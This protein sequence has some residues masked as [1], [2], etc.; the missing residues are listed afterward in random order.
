MRI[1]VL[2]AL[3]LSLLGAAHAAP[4]SDAA[5]A[6]FAER[7]ALLAADAKCTLL[8]APVRAALNAT[9]GQARM[10]AIRAG[11]TDTRLD[12]VSTRA[13]DAGR[14]RDCKDPLVIDAAQRATAGYAG[15]S[16]QQGVDLP[17][18]SRSWRVRRLGDINGWVLAQELSP[19]VRF[20]L[21]YNTA[22][23]PVFVLTAPLAEMGTLSSVQV[24]LRDRTR[25]PRPLLNVPGLLPVSGLAGGVAPRSL[26]ATW[27][28]SKITVERV[29][30]TPPMVVVNFPSGL[31]AELASLD[32]RETAE[33][34]LTRVGAPPQRF[35]VEIG[36]LNVARAFLSAGAA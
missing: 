7:A 26:S 30:D 16:K 29:K 19:N 12:G 34:T 15:W 10:D 35:Y 17:G 1:S 20:G 4:A 2:S 8:A 3:W 36:D 14:A 21:K 32:P 6:L 11:W 28:A 31:M 5:A 9:T 13:A 33:I 22:H 24:N 27:I 25:A 18:V 23:E